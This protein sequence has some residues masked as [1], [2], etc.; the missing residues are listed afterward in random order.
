MKPPRELRSSLRHCFLV[1]SSPADRLW[2]VMVGNMARKLFNWLK[3]LIE[4]DKTGTH[5]GLKR[6]ALSAFSG[7]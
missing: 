5:Q 6:C 7:Q 4:E 3:V 1:R 2:V